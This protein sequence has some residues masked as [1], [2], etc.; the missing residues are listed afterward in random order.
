MSRLSSGNACYHSVQNRC[1]RNYCVRIYRTVT[2][3]A[4]P[5][6]DVHTAQ[7]KYI[8]ISL[9]H[10]ACFGVCGKGNL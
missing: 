4:Q 3:P 8:Y 2:V 9:L 6:G 10:G 1:L 5:Q 7:H